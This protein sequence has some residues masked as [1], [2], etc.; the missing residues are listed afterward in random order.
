[1]KHINCQFVKRIYE[2][3]ITFMDLYI[4]PETFSCQKCSKS[5]INDNIQISIR[6][7]DALYKKK[8][9]ISF[10][11]SIRGISRKPEN[12]FARIAYNEKLLTIFAKLFVLDICDS[13]G[14]APCT[15]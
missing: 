2:C 10:P 9:G 3:E 12:I 4:F 14:Y 7:S 5:R 11:E 13:L 8:T 6:I 15:A 1:M